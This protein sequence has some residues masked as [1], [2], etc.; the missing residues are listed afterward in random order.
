MRF[1]ECLN[2]TNPAH[3]G[4][5]EST[6]R[7]CLALQSVGHQVELLTLDEKSTPWLANWPTRAHTLGPGISRFGYSPQVARWM[8]RNAADFDA[9]VVNGV[10]RYLGA[11]VRSGLRSLHVPYFVIPH[12]M[13]N[14]WFQQTM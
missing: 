2:S 8:S 9:I 13:L 5:V 10:W 12:S 11:G 3:G 7:R 14:P 6:R 4:T 1:L